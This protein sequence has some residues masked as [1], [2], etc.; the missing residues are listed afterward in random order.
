MKKIA[1]I[2]LSLL[3]MLGVFAGCKSGDNAGLT[4]A[5]AYLT[6]MYQTAGKD[7][8][9]NML[10]DKDVLSVVTID[11]VT[12]S[13][14][15]TVEVTKGAK[16]AVK[17][18]E[19]YE[20]NHVLIDVPDLP[21]KD[22]LF[23]ATATIKDDKGN[24][25]TV[26]FDYKV[27]GLNP[28]AG[29][30]DSSDVASDET[31]S[32]ATESEDKDNANTN[33]SSKKDENTNTNTSSKGNT[34][35]NTNTSSK[36][37]TTTN[38]APSDPKAIVD[39]AYALERN[40]QLDYEA[41]LT[42]KVISVNEAYDAEFENV[43]V[44][45]QVEGKED[46]P[47]KCYRMK[48][49]G[50]DKVK[51]G[52][53]ITVKGTLKNYKGRVK[54]DTGCALTKRVAGQTETTVLT[55]PKKIVEAAFKLAPGEDMGYDVTLTGKVVSIDSAYNPDFNN[56]S[57]LIEVEGKEILCYRMTG[58]AKDIK[59]VVGGDTLTVTGR[60]KN[61]N[62]T[63]EFDQG[64]VMRKRVSGGVT[65]ETDPKKIVDAAFALEKG[66]S[67]PYSVTLTG[68]ITKIATPYDAGYKNITVIIEVE[69]TKGTE[70]LKCYRMKGEGAENL[71]VGDTIAVSGVIKNYVHSSGD[72]EI[73]FDA[74]C[75]F[76]LK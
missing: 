13:V 37:N 60:I 11:G 28:D 29:D 62:G 12:Y 20:E 76:I 61:Y 23:T 52:D 38:K 44:T 58:T 46:K 64:C 30:D 17:V 41:T 31:S 54:F 75:T 21:E 43:T 55:D 4:D 34:N 3:M 35:T 57:V 56:V 1:S 45:I 33:T 7:E 63:I 10:M 19:S 47:I 32:D 59:A 42:G 72:N 15:W 73:E 48:G 49:T 16:D 5:K 65:V 25:E 24:T 50:A 2:A 6:N 66:K 36:G 51:K 74:G 68:K 9:M 27:T 53:T 40:T 18:G 8:V 67:L 26:S 14:E 70:E 69:G 39:A 22:I 71:K